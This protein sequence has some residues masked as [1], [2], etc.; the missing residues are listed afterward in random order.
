MI[1]RM[2]VILAGL[3]LAGLLLA[4]GALAQNAV[5]RPLRVGVLTDMNGTVANVVGKGSVV[6]ARLAIEDNGGS[7]LGRPIELLSGDTQAKPDIAASI[8]R[9]WYDEEGVDAVVDV[10]NTAVAM[11][12]Q[13]ISR[14]KHKI[15]L[16]S[17]PGSVDLYG[18]ACSPTGFLWTYDTA[19]LSRGTANAVFAEGGTSWFFITTD[20]S[21]GI[22]L[23][24]DTGAVVQSLGGTV[25]GDMRMP[26][27]TS[28]FSSPLLKAQSSGAKVIALA[29]AGTDTINAI[30]GAHEFGLTQSG[31][32][33]AALVL[34][35]T[36]VHSLGLETVGGTYL[37]TAFYWDMDDA[38]R[39]FSKRFEAEMGRPPTMLQAGAYSALNHYLKAVKQAGTAGATEVAAAMR[40]M[41]V[42]DAFTHGARIRPDGRLVRDMYLAQVKMPAESKGP[43]DVYRIVRTLPGST[44]LPPAEQSACTL[45]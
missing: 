7:V 42:D 33:I 13:T 6:A 38:T 23:Q 36:D 22:Q 20:Y 2:S 1:G 25:L 26:P 4:G 21:F 12:V 41:P 39:A 16:L 35:I 31:R 43:W 30:K 11:A 5:V 32:S 44:L 24:R 18:S 9:R 17:A 28:D 37:T 19:A 8:V 34:F 40:A 45:N 14:E 27:G 29:N 10:P 3:L 15:A